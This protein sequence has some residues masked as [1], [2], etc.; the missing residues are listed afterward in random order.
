MKSEFSSPN[1]VESMLKEVKSNLNHLESLLLTI[2]R[3]EVLNP[4]KNKSKK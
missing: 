1:T 4:I 3:S 2:E